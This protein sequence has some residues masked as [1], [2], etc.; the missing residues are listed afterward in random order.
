MP[1]RPVTPGLLIPEIIANIEFIDDVIDARHDLATLGDCCA[2][3]CA[4]YRAMAICLLSG[5]ADVEGFF[6]HLIAPS[7]TSASIRSNS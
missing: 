3:L 4:Q 5:Q 6:D 2:D 7:C 1:T